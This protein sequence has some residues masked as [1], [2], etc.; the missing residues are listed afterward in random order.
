M[1]PVRFEVV[2]DLDSRPRIV[3]DELTDWK[4]HEDWIPATR[5]EV[6]GD[7]PTAPGTELV[8]WTGLGRLAL[9]DRMAVTECAWNDEI[10]SGT[11]AVTK[12][13]PVLGGRAGF[14]V[15]PSPR[16]TRVVWIEDVTVRRLPRVL[17]PVVARLGSIGFRLAMW[18]LDRLLAARHRSGDVPEAARRAQG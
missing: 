8:A 3:W 1:A 10:Q 9:E 12:L 4:G 11:C 13:G 14:T 16:G 2:V 7:D 6:H 18:R 5:V 15:E 17:G